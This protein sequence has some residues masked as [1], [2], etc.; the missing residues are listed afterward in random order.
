MLII[1]APSR[2]R[3]VLWLVACESRLGMPTVEAVRWRRVESRPRLEGRRVAA[4]WRA[5]GGEAHAASPA[6][7]GGVDAS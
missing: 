6:V 2:E 7:R 4:A 1:G 5:D 3:A